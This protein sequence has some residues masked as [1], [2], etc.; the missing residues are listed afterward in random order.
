MPA[1]S[2]AAAVG[3]PSKPSSRSEFSRALRRCANPARTTRKKNASSVTETRAERG[4]QLHGDD[5][6]GA[7]QQRLRQDPPSR[8]DLQHRLARLQLC[9][10]DDLVDDVL[11][12]EEVLPEGLA[13]DLRGGDAGARTGP[14]HGRSRFFTNCTASLIASMR[15]PSSATALPTMS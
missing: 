7:V 5:E 14:R 3:A 13:G 6:P 15:L 9:Q 4:V 12:D 2:N 8:A 11:I 1:C 10:A